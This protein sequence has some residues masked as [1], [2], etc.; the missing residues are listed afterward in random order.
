MSG[1]INYIRKS[2]S[3]PAPVGSLLSRSEPFILESGNPLSPFDIAYETYGTLNDEGTNAILVCHALTGNAHAGNSA[4]AN[5]NSAPGWW[6]GI[7]GSGKGLDTDRYCV[8]C[9]NILGSCYGTTG[10]ASIDPRSGEAYRMN[11]P[12]VTVR[13]MVRAQRL[14]LGELGVRKLATVIG[15]SLG[16]MQVLEWAILYPDFVESIIPIATAARHS[17]WCIGF[18][19]AQRLAILSDPAWRGGEYEEQPSAGLALARMIAM[20]SYRSQVSFEERFGR[21]AQAPDDPRNGRSPFTSSEPSFQVESYLRYQGHKLVDRFDASSYVYLTR[22]MDMHDVGSNRGGVE[23]ALGS[24]KARA[25]C[26]GI[27]SD[28]L[29]PASEQRAIARCIPRSRYREIESPHGHDAFLIEFDQLNEM[30]SMHLR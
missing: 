6:S 18:N 11:F 7:I 17:A 25:L 27:S 10:P 23:Q 21:A 15:G 9:S 26:I 29:Y 3:S 16:G 28:I 8:I 12:Q 5:G 2:P 24:I 13:D 4:A 30:I 20:I 14:L 22:A 19:E 1:E